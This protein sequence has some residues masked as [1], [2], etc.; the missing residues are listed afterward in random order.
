MAKASVIRL[1]SV[2]GMA[3]LACSAFGFGSDSTPT[4]PPSSQLADRA[5]PTGPALENPVQVFDSLGQ[6]IQ[7]EEPPQDFLDVLNGQ[8]AAGQV[9]EG[10]MLISA[11]RALVGET[12]QIDLLRGANV[13]YFEGS[14]LLS[15]AARYLEEGGDAEAQAE[16]ER[17][18]EAVLPP[19]ENIDRYAQPESQAS[20]ANPHFG[21]LSLPLPDE[22]ACRELWKEGFPPDAAS[23]VC[24]LYS[25]FTASGHQYRVYYPESKRTSPTYVNYVRAAEEGLAQSIATFAPLTAVDDIT[26]VFALLQS[27]LEGSSGPARA[28]THLTGMDTRLYC[29]IVIYPAALTESLDNFKQIIAHEVFHCVQAWRTGRNYNYL[30]EVWHIEGM[31]NYFSNVVY[32]SIN[33]EH[34]FQGRFDYNSLDRTFFTMS[35]ENSTLFQYLGNTWGNDKVIRMIDLL[36]PLA[37]YPAQSAALV[38]YG[39]DQAT[40]HQ[41]GQDYLDK[42]IADT[43]GGALPINVYYRGVHK[44]EASITLNLEA[45]DFLLARDLIQYQENTQYDIAVSETGASGRNAVKEWPNGSGWGPVP[46][47][48]RSQCGQ[49][50][51]V[52]LMTAAEGSGSNYEL[53]FDITQSDQRPCNC[54]VGTWEQDPAEAHRILTEIVSGLGTVTDVS[55]QRYMVIT[56]EGEDEPGSIS[57]FPANACA[58]VI[59]DDRAGRVCVSGVSTS[60]YTMAGD[61][62]MNVFNE[63]VSFVLTLTTS[64]GSIE[65]PVTSDSLGGPSTS[66]WEV[67]CTETTLTAFTGGVAPFDTSSYRRTSPVP[68]PEPP[69]EVEGPGG[70]GG[71]GEFE[72]PP[73]GLPISPACSLLAIDNFSVAASQTSWTLRNASSEPAD[74]IRVSL[75]W[76]GAN[77]AWQSV[78]LGGTQIWSGSQS[79]S[80]AVVESGWS[81]AAADRSVAPG[82]EAELDLAFAA[83][84]APSGYIVVIDFANGCLLSSVE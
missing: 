68:T 3:T 58:T 36:E 77:G 51:H 4:Q 62:Q 72:G 71:G 44:I 39:L 73:G 8:V 33:L 28:V 47:S 14:G 48:F 32:P 53:Q 16:I 12:E 64:E 70:P 84:A 69:D 42:Q 30:D 17:L 65:M 23:L 56:A 52:L 55:G 10:D 18:L 5:T 41:F 43:G 66:S 2:L 59:V 60:Q 35:Y 9:S 1:V 7:I 63:A 57:L 81:G 54:V 74:I 31:A 24:L 75:D 79:A 22:A 83:S 20:L 80:P 49:T 61:T 21:H 11:L 29:P 82:A 40:W 13:E 27:T 34:R 45:K 76:P 15:Q 19:Q 67:Q 26:I 78:S 25:D 38:G 46:T 50:G 6:A 37:G